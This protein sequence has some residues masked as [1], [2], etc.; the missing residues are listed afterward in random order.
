MSTTVREPFDAFT[1]LRE[2]VTRFLDEGVT[3][4]DRLLMLGH[5]FPVDVI[6]TPDEY[7]VEA[8]LTGIRPE[9]VQITTTGNTLTIR[10][11]RKPHLRHE[12][13]GTYLRRERIERH[14]PEMSRTLTL[15][16]RINPDK[17]SADY[18]NGVLVVTVGKDE[19]SKP[20]TIPLH[21]SKD[22]VER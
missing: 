14:G 6:E 11:G 2:A 10:V 19:E 17:V 22:K 15:P 18:Q 16:A 7:I 5:T 21:V 20:R 12:E 1:P 3:S 4:P 9:N 8:S 13:D